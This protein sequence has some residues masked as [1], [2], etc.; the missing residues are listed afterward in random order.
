MT[1][2]SLRVRLCVFALLVPGSLWSQG[3]TGS[4]VGTITDPAN[5]VV[6][7]AKVT[8]K[9]LN[10][11]A[12][13][14]ATTDASGT[15]R[16]LGL[17]SGEY[18]V[19]A[20]APGF[21]TSSTGPVTVDISTPA[22]VD[23]KLEVGQVTEVI[24]VESTAAQINTEDAQLGRVLRNVSELPLLSGN[25][26]RNPLSLV[27]IQPGVSMPTGRNGTG[28][29]NFV[30]PFSINGA[31]TQSNNYLLDGGDSN[32]LAINVPDSVLQISPD[33]LAEFRLITGAA[34]AEYGRNAAT[35][36]VVTKSGGN[37]FHGDLTEVFRNKVLNATP[38]FQ[39]NTPGP[40]ETFSNGL[41][42]K[43]DY[44]ANDFDG[45]LGGPIKKDKTFFLISYLGFRRVQGV[46]N[47]ATVFT[48]QERL[49]ISQVGTPSAKTLLAMV[50]SASTG[51]LLFSAPSNS[52]H[53]D[54]GIAKIDHR[55]S[56]RNTLSGSY[57]IEHQTAL[58]P[59][60]FGGTV[61]PGFGTVGTTRYQNLIVR[62]T[63]TFSATVFN[64]ARASVHRRASPSVIPVNNTTPASIGLSGVVPDDPAAAGPP[65]IRI[66]GISE[67]GNT[68]QGPRSRFDTTYQYSDTLSWIKGK[69]AWKF[70]GDYRAYDQ[71]Q[72][73]EFINNGVYTFDG[74]ARKPARCPRPLGWP[75]RSTILRAAMCRISNRP[76]RAARD[77]ATNSSAHLSRTTGK[78]AAT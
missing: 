7:N 51:S 39:K 2:N 67:F 42:R 13:V 61:I 22:R 49:L 63:H 35:I 47:S 64:E 66:N 23:L 17:V 78:S 68:I 62:D 41:P 44:K 26:G 72:L 48:D 65:S 32:D 46:S 38:F 37:A 9:N 30:G 31:R 60:P 53:R 71:N 11:N 52:L 70:G 54:Q 40:V 27:G 55:I 43:P 24:S 20:Q 4:I 33:A 74:T 58:D 18:R 29:T 36:E 6:P 10:T 25:N 77:T 1:L 34:K 73:F 75:L 8:V 12:E 50:P 56:D 5:A 28:T 15:Y 69:H 16:V 45:D 19:S 76:A 21:R 14:P 57:F 3:L 59:F